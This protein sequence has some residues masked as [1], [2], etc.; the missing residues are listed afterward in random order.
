MS[1]ISSKIQ[2]KGGRARCPR[3][4]SC[5]Q[6]VPDQSRPHNKEASV[7]HFKHERCWLLYFFPGRNGVK[8]NRNGTMMRN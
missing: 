7:A 4:S 3:T 2:H 8:R 5:E 1:V 6:R